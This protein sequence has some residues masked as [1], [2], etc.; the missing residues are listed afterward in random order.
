MKNKKRK[1]LLKEYSENTDLK[2]A[3]A[4]WLLGY[5][6]DEY[7]TVL[8]DLSYGGCSSGMVSSLIYYSETTRFY[9]TYKEEIWELAEE[10]AQE[11]GHKNALEMISNF[12]GYRDGA[13][14]FENIMAWYSFEETARSVANELEIEV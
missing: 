9:G 11:L 6:K 4:D 12:N 10:Q 5:N 14:Q 3:V 1:K 13:T 2:G 7:E 8:K